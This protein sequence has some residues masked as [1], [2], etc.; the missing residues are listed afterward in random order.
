MESEDQFFDY[1]I[2][3]GSGKLD[4]K[5]DENKISVTFKRIDKDSKET[6]VTY[7]LKIWDYDKYIPYENFNTVALT[8]SLYYTVFKRNPKIE[9]DNTVTL[10]A[11]RDFSKWCY[12]QVIAH[13]QQNTALEYVAYEGVYN[14]KTIHMIQIIIEIQIGQIIQI[15]Q[16][17]LMNLK[18]EKTLLFF[19]MY[20]L[21][22]LFWL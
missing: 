19:L 3:G 7:F 16:S 15:K 14:G 12:I 8:E 18:K 2:V 17:Q 13:I 22:F 9:S 1:I 4:I 6:N 5:E 10:T 21:L 11:E 20:Q